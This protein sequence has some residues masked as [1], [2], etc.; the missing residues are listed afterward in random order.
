[1]E[2]ESHVNRN[3]YDTFFKGS[4]FDAALPLEEFPNSL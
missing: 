2:I 4:S 1:M 3:V